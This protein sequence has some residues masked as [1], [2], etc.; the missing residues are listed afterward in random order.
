MLSNPTSPRRQRFADSSGARGRCDGSTQVWRRCVSR[1]AASRA[2][3][4]ELVRELVYC[5]DVPAAANSARTPQPLFAVRVAALLLAAGCGGSQ[6][7]RFVE[8]T[9]AAQIDPEATEV[10]PTY[11]KHE[12]ERVIGEERQAHAAAQSVLASLMDQRGKAVEIALRLAD[13]GVQERYLETLESCK[14]RGVWCPPKLGMAWTIREGV[15]V[16]VSLDTEVRFDLQTWRAVTAELWAR[17]CDCR[18]MTC[19]DA[20]T[21]TI[22]ALEPRPTPEVQGDQEASAALT[23]ARTCL[24]RLRGKAGQRGMRVEDVAGS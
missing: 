15:D 23:A 6:T 16:P 10:V 12:L 14:A 2:V 19:V 20:M 22:D 3:A 24:W 8:P 18:S 11:G 9:Q 7:E 17:G 21:Q 4:A 13:L 5:H 1:R